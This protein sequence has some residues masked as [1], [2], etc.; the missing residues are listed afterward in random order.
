METKVNEQNITQCN[1][2]KYYLWEFF[3]RSLLAK[4]EVCDVVDQ[5][6]A[7]LENQT[8]EWQRKNSTA[9]NIIVEYLSDAFLNFVKDN[10]TAKGSFD[11]LDAYM[12]DTV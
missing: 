10:S 1:G 12:K 4:Y 11:S 8:E 6:L 7:A 2:D 5:T 3:V 9:K